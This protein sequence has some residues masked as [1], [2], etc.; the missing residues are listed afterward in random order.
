LDTRIG[1]KPPPKSTDL[2]GWRQ[3]IADDLLRT[4][5]LEAIAAAF[6]DLGQ[7]D[8]GVRNAL[9]KHLSDS[10]LRMLRGRV[11]FHHPNNGEDIVFRVHGQ[12][13]EALLRPTS[14][15]GRN[16]REAFVPRLLF[17]LKDAIAAEARE[18]RIPDETKLPDKPRGKKV[19]GGNENSAVVSP[20]QSQSPEEPETPDDG[21]MVPQKVRE[22]ARFDGED[23]A[24]ERIDVDRI[25]ECVPD[26]KKRLAFQLFMDEV[27]YGSK[28]KDVYT[29]AQ[30]LDIS[31][32]TARDWI[33]EVRQLLAGNEN[34]KH[35]KERRAGDN[36]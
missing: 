34:V 27:P 32:K 2:D 36:I 22:S 13:F 23:G 9:A 31:D 20:E 26:Y 12:L 30:A 5:R 17:R 29:I 21:E 28:K 1:E 25:L 10:V 3:A 19:D 15:D 4:L 11:G 24:N 16:L 8:T 14:A 35:H 6:Q 18:R 33:K 7:C